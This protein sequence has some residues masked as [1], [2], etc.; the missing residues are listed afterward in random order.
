[1]PYQRAV[2]QWA[3]YAIIFSL[4]FGLRKLLYQFTFGFDE[5]EA[6]ALYA[7]DIAILFFLSALAII[8][9]RENI[10]NWRAVPPYYRL[11]LIFLTLSAVSI[12]I[13]SYK[14]LALYQ[15]FRLILLAAFALGVGYLTKEKIINIGSVFACIVGLS[16]LEAVLAFLQVAWQKSIGLWVLGEPL[17][18]INIPGVAKIIIDGAPI[19]RGYGTFPHSNV[20]AA[21]LLMGLFS[22]YYFF[23]SSEAGNWFG[24]L[25]LRNMGLVLAIFI[26]LLGILVTFSR[27]A[28][29]VGAL[30]TAIFLF[31]AWFTESRRGTR[32]IHSSVL[33]LFLV[34]SV[35][36][37]SLIAK[38][39]WAVVS[40]AHISKIEP[41]V[42][43]RLSYNELGAGLIADHPLGV[44]IGNQVIFSVK[45]GL[46]Q[47]M[48]MK[49]AWQW[50][51]IH[52]IYL[53]MAVEVGIFGALT[54]AGFLFMLMTPAFRRIM[55]EGVLRLELLMVLT[56]LA[57]LLLLGLI[58]HFSWTLQPGRLMLWLAIGLVMGLNEP[59]KHL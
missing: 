9:W 28:W 17:L 55:Q 41:S 7:S 34:L 3:L 31:S 58:D 24:N 20:L 45:N 18:G 8:F 54:F 32:A 2:L 1:M 43:Y 27:A 5:Y 39:G 36:L 49:E 42:S 53:L 6:I 11:L 40:R 22:A 51:P 44:G 57:A 10:L 47:A 19:I 52:N 29:A 15:F 4:P 26:L 30:M 16:A 23:L 25:R 59:K 46:Y 21:F 33:A 50:Q 12:F 13:A 56:M 37:F 38:F 35:L 14:L 48:G